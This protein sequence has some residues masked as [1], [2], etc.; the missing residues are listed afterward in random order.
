[1]PRTAAPA[2]AGSPGSE[3]PGG[4][5]ALVRARPRPPVAPELRPAPAPSA[6]PHP[7]SAFPW[8][9]FGGPARGGYA[10]LARRAAADRAAADPRAS[11]AG[12]DAS[13]DVGR[14]TVTGR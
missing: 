13:G 8:F 7:A 1:V 4:S 5:V 10:V 3:D 11:D 6:G 2:T 12:R 14:Q 9:L